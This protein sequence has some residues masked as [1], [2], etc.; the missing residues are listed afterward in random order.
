MGTKNS[1]EVDATGQVNNNVIIDETVNVHNQQFLI[2]LW[3]ICIIKIVEFF[4]TLLRYYGKNIK[5]KY[6]NQSIV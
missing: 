2:I 1:K 4:S 6:T 5:R 3:I